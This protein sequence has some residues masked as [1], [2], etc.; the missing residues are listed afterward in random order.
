MANTRQISKEEL[1]MK[2]YF[3]ELKEAG[4]IKK[5]EYQPAP[6]ILFNKVEV[7]IHKQLKTKVKIVPKTLLAERLYTL[8][9]IIHWN[10]RNPLHEPISDDYYNDKLPVFF[11]D[12]NKTYIEIKA[13]RDLQNTTRFFNSRTQPWIWEKF[14]IFI[15][16]IKVP[17]IFEETF[18]PKAILH[19][20]Y[21]KRDVKIKGKLKARKGD[22]KFKWEYRTLD[23]F[24]KN[25][26]K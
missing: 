16:L 18:I 12:M 8:D 24:I 15:N 9:F 26:T 1:G 4:F 11:S 23:T 22:P 13:I 7:P 10:D 5:I 6:I 19:D 25:V 20:F 2:A 14:N 3:E 21:Y 17:K